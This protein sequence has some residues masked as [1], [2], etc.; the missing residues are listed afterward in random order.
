ME[1]QTSIP[2]G[3]P[4]LAWNAP[5][6]AH[7]IRSER[8]YAIGGIAVILMAAYGIIT[9]AWTFTVV[10]V[11]CGAMYVLLRGH[12]PPL[13]SIAFW[14]QGLLYERMFVRWQDI[15]GFWF[16][17]ARDF[18][19]LHFAKKTDEEEIMIHV[20]DVDVEELRRTLSHFAPELNNKKERLLDVLI[21]ICKL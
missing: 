7:H 10:I 11:L 19:E 5:S 14:E 16:T 13:K 20:R 12:T 3:D 21:R 4:M 6:T 2:T 8:W 9:G 18:T 17:Y 15:E 1:L